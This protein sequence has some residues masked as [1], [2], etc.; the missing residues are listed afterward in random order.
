MFGKV[1]AVVKAAPGAG[2]VSS[3][4]LQSDD[5]DEIDWEWVGS[6]SEQVQ[7]NYFG[8]GITGSYNRGAFNPALDC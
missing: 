8:K 1:E 6:D 2:I 7:T 4:V 3:V 5:R